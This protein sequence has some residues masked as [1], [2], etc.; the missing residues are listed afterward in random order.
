MKIVKKIF[1]PATPQ[2]FTPIRATTTSS[3]EVVELLRDKVDIPEPIAEEITET[4]EIPP[5]DEDVGN[6]YFYGEEEPSSR[7]YEQN[8]ILILGDKWYNTSNGIEYTYLPEF[9]GSETLKWIPTGVTGVGGGGGIGE[10]WGITA[11]TKATNLEGIPSGTTFAIGTSATKILEKLL[12]PT[13]LEFTSFDIGITPKIYHVGDKSATGPKLAEWELN[14]FEKAQENSLRIV[15]GSTIFP[16]AISLSPSDINVSINHQTEYTRNSE[17]SVN[18]TI[19]VTGESGETVSRTSSL[20][21]RYPVYGGKTSGSSVTSLTDIQSLNMSSPTPNNPIISYSMSQLKSGVTVNVPET[22]NNGSE[23]FYWVVTKEINSSPVSPTPPNYNPNVG[24]FSD[25][26]DPNAPL[27]LPMQQM[28]DITVS[29]YGLN[30]T[31]SVYRS[32][33]NFGGNMIIKTRE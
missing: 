12:Y 33:N 21:W 10:P 30:I 11:P 31:F 2:I 6:Q 5:D 17:G 15:Q 19:S 24:S 27:S 26:T 20:L 4:Y 18:F 28:N 25:V 29:D 8:S 3:Y 14:D 13:F 22:P 9:E 1:I 16:E 23:Y 7:P 32:V